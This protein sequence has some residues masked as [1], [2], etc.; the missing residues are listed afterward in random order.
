MAGR[1]WFSGLLYVQRQ[2]SAV[3][4]LPLT[5]FQRVVHFTGGDDRRGCL[6]SAAGLHR[7]RRAQGE[8]RRRRYRGVST[9]AVANEFPNNTFFD[10]HD[11][12]I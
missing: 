11:F 9:D 10:K 6:L 2:L 3:A 5:L 4:R 7:L 8:R 1:L 12:K